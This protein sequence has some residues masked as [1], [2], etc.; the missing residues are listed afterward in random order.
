MRTK[1]ELTPHA[2][3]LFEEVKAALPQEISRRLRSNRTFTTHGSYLTLYNFDVWDGNQTDILD[4]KHF[5]YCLGHDYRPG[6]KRDG[7]FH[8]W[9]NRVRIYRERESILKDLDEKLPKI[10]PSGFTWHP[11]DRAYNIGMEFDYPSDLQ[12]LP[13]LLLPHCV[14]LISA[15]HP[16]LIPIID[17]FT[18]PLRQG[19]RR[20]VV[21]ERGRID[22]TPVG[23]HDRARVREYTRSIP[24]SWRNQLLEQYGYRCANPE[25][26]ADLRSVQHHIDHILAFSKGGLTALE[27]LQPLCEPCNL[28]KGNRQG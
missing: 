25:C 16:I 5:K 23:V 17:Q 19:E 4:R 20:A 7:Y 12:D 18:T 27:N 21:A 3:R 14:A 11:G 26:G 8:L 24:P 2:L 28:A 22:F 10:V 1:E 13:A 15:V 9:L 6:A